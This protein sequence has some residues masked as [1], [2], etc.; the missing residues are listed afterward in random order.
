[1]EDQSNVGP[2]I[3]RQRTIIIS[4]DADILGS[5]TNTTA[6]QENEDSGYPA[7]IEVTINKLTKL[8]PEISAAIRKE[9]NENSCPIYG[10]SDDSLNH[11]NTSLHLLVKCSM[12]LSRAFQADSIKSILTHL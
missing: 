1:M 7:A 2:L 6:S 5:I 4:N 10:L 11:S 8:E 12:A 3:K 9:N